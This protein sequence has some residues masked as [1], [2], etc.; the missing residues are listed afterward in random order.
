MEADGRTARCSPRHRTLRPHRLLAGELGELGAT[1][2]RRNEGWIEEL[3]GAD[4]TV[5]E[6]GEAV[7]VRT[8]TGGGYGQS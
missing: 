8:P 4:Q 2:V 5:L 6:A 7:I 1:F 3:L